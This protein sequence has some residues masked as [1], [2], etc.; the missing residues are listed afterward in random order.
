MNHSH[1][2]MSVNRGSVASGADGA[3]KP[4]SPVE[5]ALHAN[6]SLARWLDDVEPSVIRL[7]VQPR[8]PDERRRPPAAHPK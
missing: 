6:D 5:R 4:P 2:S 1:A 8:P 3:G 7:A